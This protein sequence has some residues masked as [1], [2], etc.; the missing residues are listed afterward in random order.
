[1]GRLHSTS[2]NS[3]TWGPERERFSSIDDAEEDEEEEAGE[4]RI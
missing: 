3:P 2:T 4:L 1:M